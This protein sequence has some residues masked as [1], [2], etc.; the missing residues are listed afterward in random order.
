M[1]LRLNFFAFIIRGMEKLHA[2]L[3]KQGAGAK[4][5]LASHLQIA[6]TFLS[7]ILKGRKPMP[8]EALARLHDATGGAVTP[9]DLRPD[10]AA[11]FAPKEPTQ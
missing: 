2:Y 3:E 9:A 8:M 4:G 10:L 7:Q 5:A 1:F 6:P 11:I